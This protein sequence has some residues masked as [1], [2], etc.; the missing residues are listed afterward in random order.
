[1][2][3][4]GQGRVLGQR[5]RRLSLRVLQAGSLSRCAADVLVKG[6]RSLHCR[7]QHLH[8]RLGSKLA[9]SALKIS[10]TYG[11]EGGQGSSLQTSASVLQYLCC[12]AKVCLL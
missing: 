8:M 2:L 1:M 12:K 9:C 11:H 7:P 5:A 10:S 4:A 3:V 6:P